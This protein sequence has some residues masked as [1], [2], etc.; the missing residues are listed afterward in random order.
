[1]KNGKVR[2]F[3]VAQWSKN[4]KIQFEKK[5]PLCYENEQA[6]G[7]WWK[8][9]PSSMKKVWMFHS[10]QKRSKFNFTKFE[11]MPTTCVPK[12]TS[13]QKNFFRKVFSFLILSKT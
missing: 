5:L 11:I 2:I 13:Y 10:G 6:R 7:L 3:H 12:M 8:F 4:V 1:M 9:H